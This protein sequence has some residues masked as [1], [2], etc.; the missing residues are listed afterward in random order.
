MMYER[1]HYKN[2]QRVQKIIEKEVLGNNF[3][4]EKLKLI[5]RHMEILIESLNHWLFNNNPKRYFYDLKAFLDWL[6]KQ[7]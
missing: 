3:N 2:I 5:N 6:K 1:N 4:L 7:K